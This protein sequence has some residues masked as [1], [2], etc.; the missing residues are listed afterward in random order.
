[1]LRHRTW[2]GQRLDTVRTVGEITAALCT[3]GRMSSR[4]LGLM[5][6]GAVIV[7]MAIPAA[8]Q[9]LDKAK[10]DEVFRVPQQDP[11]ME[12]AFQKA[13]AS[14]DEFLTIAREPRK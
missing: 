6:A 1:M 3:G 12:A 2:L 10:R 9:V 11:A 5:M 7:G 13:R 4:L 8:A 14:M